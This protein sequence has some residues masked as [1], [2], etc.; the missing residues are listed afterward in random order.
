VSARK[1]ERYEMRAGRFSSEEEE[2][3]CILA[4]MSLNVSQFFV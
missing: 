1:E 3:C 2:M 4:T